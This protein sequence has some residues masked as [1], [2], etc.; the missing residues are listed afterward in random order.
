M[1][2]KM[3]SRKEINEEMK[4]IARE[5]L[6]AIVGVGCIFAIA[7]FG[8]GLFA[9][10]SVG[11]VPIENRVLI[12]GIETS[13]LGILVGMAMQ[14]YHEKRLQKKRLEKHEPL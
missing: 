4:R 5:L 14:K 8:L 7:L 2:L 10:V 6:G 13:G 3:R 11:K 12:V 9:L 1:H